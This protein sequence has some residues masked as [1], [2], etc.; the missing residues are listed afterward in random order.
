M[1]IGRLLFVVML[2]GS[3]LMLATG[4]FSFAASQ[5]ASSLAYVISGDLTGSGQFGVVNLKT[6]D[7]RRIGPVE[8]DG[9]F[10][11]APGRNGLLFALTYAGNLDSI[12][13]AT[14]VHELIGPTGLGACL[15]P[16]SACGPTS[17]FSLGGFEGRVYATDFQNNLYIVSPETGEATPL[18]RNTGLPANPFVPG[19][20]NEDG[21]LNFADEAIWQSGQKLFIIYDAWVFDPATGSVASV[22][23]SPELYEIDPATGHATVIG[24]TELGIGGVLS[25]D[26]RDY[27]FDDLTNQILA[28][29]LMNGSTR[30]VGSFNGAAGV[31]Q[32]AVPHSLGPFR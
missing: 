23:V 7:F 32:G 22:V 31:I 24:P 3:A 14:G 18:S 12:N 21:T 1:K 10:G 17:A 5:E 19:S 16:S 8:P 4:L 20:Q 28:I 9:Y 30:P 26:G 25:F 2:F 15:I 27:A 11:L 29:S 13:P 6:G